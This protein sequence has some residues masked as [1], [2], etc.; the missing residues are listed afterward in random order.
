MSLQRSVEA[1]ETDPADRQRA[2][3]ALPPA[4]ERMIRVMLVDDSAVIR[5]LVGRIIDAE[6]DMEVTASAPNGKAA[7]EILRHKDVDVIVLDVEMPEMDGLTA[8]PLIL[9]AKPGTRVIM[10][11]SLT[12]RGADVTMRALGLG[13]ADYIPKPSSLSAVQGME[14]ISRDLVAKVRALGRDREHVPE[15]PQP[16]AP[17]KPEVPTTEPVTPPRVL[18][19]AASTGGP[20]ALARVLSRLPGDFPLPILIAQHM[21]PLFTQSL[22]ERLQRESGRQCGE[23]RDG[24]IIAGGRICIAPGDF[25]MRVREG[26]RGV[27]ARLD[28]EPPVNF[29]RPSA[30]PLLQSVAVTYGAA[31]LA[32]VLTGM[33][34][35][36]L[37]GCEAVVRSGGR[38]VVQDRATSVVWGMPGTVANAGLAS[39]VLPLDEIPAHLG[40]LCAVPV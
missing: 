19:I 14:A 1:I 21:P 15:K 10:A 13:A 32:L 5:G 29:C 38:V 3:I 18:C 35:D 31:S 23:A 12:T 26:E 36:G 33:G 24:D 28:Q 17:R 39:A 25:H 7:I 30:D 20:N 27:I 34:E 11:S 9:A 2:D 37:R 8:L 40:T 4:L 22:A 16:A 6:S